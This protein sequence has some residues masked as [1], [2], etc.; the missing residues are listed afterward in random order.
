MAIKDWTKSYT[1]KGEIIFTKGIKKLSI[2]HLSVRRKPWIVTDKDYDRQYLKEFK[3]KTHALK[4][5][6]A[7]MRKN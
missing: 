3:T 1:S 2:L 4:Y 5:A 7:Y 6:K